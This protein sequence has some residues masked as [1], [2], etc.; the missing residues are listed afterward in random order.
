MSQL[1]GDPIWGTPA[2]CLFSE[3]EATLQ[4]HGL[5]NVRSI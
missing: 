1:V 2:V 5:G 4:Q 3:D